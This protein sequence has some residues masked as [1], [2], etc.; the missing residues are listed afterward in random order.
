MVDNLKRI[1]VSGIW[2][3]AIE[4]FS[5][6]GIQFIINIIMARLLLPSDYGII[7]MLTIFLQISQI[8]IDGGF[9]NA[10]I[11][12]QN[13]TEKDYSTI[14]YFNIVVALFFYLVLFFSSPWIAQF[15]QMPDLILVT[16]VI[17][18][19]L[20]IAS[21]SSIH[22]VRLT[23]K[24]DF[25]TQSKISL[26][27]AIVSGIVGI[28]LAYNGIGVWA[29]VFQS[30]LNNLLVTIL[31][32][33]FSRWNPL[34][35]FSFNSFKSL[36]S[37]GSKLLISS[38]MH[39]V[40][41]NLYTIVIGKRFS[42]VELG[43]YTR[44]E[45]FAM[46]PSANLNAIIS[47]VTYPILSSIQ[48]DNVRLAI[49]YRKYIRLFSYIIFPLMIGIASLAEP[50]VS[51]LLTEKWIGVVI[52]LQI[53]CINWMFDHLSSINLNLLYV[54]GRSD[55]ALRLEIIK[56]IIATSILFSSIPFGII[57]MCFG[58]VFY[59]LIAVYLNTYYTKYLIGL[60][61][62]QQMKDI[63]P[64]FFISL[65]MGGVCF[66]LVTLVTGDFYKII[67]GVSVGIVVYVF[68][69][70]LFKIQSFYD[71]LWLLKGAKSKNV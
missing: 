56:K 30:I 35:L 40:Y 18:V 19:N 9:A 44:A 45:Q 26:I 25:K 39:A 57:G 66:L 43:Y 64:S 1:T 54:K 41:S 5:L 17:A 11:Q 32:Y 12:R 16:R 55:L 31:F 24:V 50:I 65:V 52:L 34:F 63:I 6:Q 7:G 69:S 36:F 37:F 10:L 59:S 53:L 48:D 22:R 68:F 23:I 20:I 58:R 2:W 27:S 60:S 49:V 61:F 51:L 14:F 4:R 42:A 13:R 62:L 3:S 46:F 71:I 28:G 29:L 21:L 70:I 8:F 15:Y 67:A 33:G 38:L 47:R